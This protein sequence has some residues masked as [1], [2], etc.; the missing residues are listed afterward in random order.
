MSSATVDLPA[1]SDVQPASV[2]PMRVFWATWAGWMLDA[3]DST[4]YGLLLVSVWRDLLPRGG[5][6]LSQ[7]LG[8]HSA[9]TFACRNPS[10]H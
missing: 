1:A 8:H 3:F 2:S 4:A 5:I 6:L 10:P 9:S 7:T